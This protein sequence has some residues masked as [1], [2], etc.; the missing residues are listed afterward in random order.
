LI[1]IEDVRNILGIDDEGS[2]IP[3]PE[4][5]EMDQAYIK[6]TGSSY[7]ATLGRQVINLDGQRYVGSV[8]WRQD[9]QTF[10]AFRLQ[11]APLKDLSINLAYVY[12]R[13][14]IFAETADA[15]S[16]DYLINAAYSTPLGKIVGYGYLLDDKTTDIQSD[17][18]GASI[19][20]AVGTH[21]KF[22]YI[23]EYA[24]QTIDTEDNNYDTDYMFLEGGLS[25]ANIT[26]K[27]GY[28][29]LGS[30]DG[31]ASFTTPLA[32]LHKFN[33]WNDIFLGGTANPTAMPNGL[34]D[35]YLSI[36]TVLTGVKLG[37]VYHEYSANKGSA[38]YGEELGFVATKG[39]TNG[40]SLG[41]KLSNYSANTYSVDTNKTW[42]WAG[43]KF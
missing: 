2:L 26:V 38:D 4:T 33:G 42:L 15:K 24:I 30:D 14:R 6:Y 40:V 12:Q 3:D 25:I 13:N 11:L 20:G 34:E 5:T 43:Y 28:E 39:F 17:T 22:S 29:I 18:F 16:K 31:T 10:D 8:S 37:A 32:T 19:S 41:L 35:T 36:D 27:L 23:A 21:V 9:K 1:E 7:N